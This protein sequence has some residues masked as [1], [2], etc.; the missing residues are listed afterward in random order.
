MNHYLKRYDVY[1]DHYKVAL[2]L[3]SVGCETTREKSHDQ[4]VTNSSNEQ[5][6]RRGECQKRDNHSST[7]HNGHSA[8]KHMSGDCIDM[9]TIQDSSTMGILNTDTDIQRDH[10]VECCSCSEPTALRPCSTYVQHTAPSVHTHG[11]QQDVNNSSLITEC[12]C[13]VCSQVGERRQSQDQS[14]SVLTASHGHE[15]GNK[16]SFLG[17]GS[18]YN[19]NGYQ[20]FKTCGKCSFHLDKHVDTSVNRS[21]IS[22]ESAN[23][24]VDKTDVCKCS[25]SSRLNNQSANNRKSLHKT[26]VPSVIS[27]ENVTYNVEIERVPPSIISDNPP[28]QTPNDSMHSADIFMSSFHVVHTCPSDCMVSSF[29]DAASGA[30]HP[31]ISR[32]TLSTDTL[33]EAP[34]DDEN[35]TIYVDTSRRCGCP[36]PARS[37]GNVHKISTSAL[38][39]PKSSSPSKQS[40]SKGSSKSGS[41]NV[42]SSSAS[43]F[44]FS[45]SSLRRRKKSKKKSSKV[46]PSASGAETVVTSPKLKEQQ[47]VLLD[48]CNSDSDLNMHSLNNVD[49]DIRLKVPQFESDSRLG[50]LEKEFQRVMRVEEDGGLSPDWYYHC[51]TFPK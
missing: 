31:G 9:S 2:D 5:D 48:N 51:Q 27:Q 33:D 20:C 28:D 22:V 40:P 49:M 7:L 6:R 24:N 35:A 8:H 12:H 13:N 39:P 50:R 10:S 36:R 1:L 18:A 43:S 38:L 37:E 15:S 3:S 23:E 4:K 46:A 17:I 29:T 19:E 25:Y 42:K 45:M 14:F 11:L 34:E 21:D 30:T 26:T 16:D 47:K 32:S 41:P 44:L